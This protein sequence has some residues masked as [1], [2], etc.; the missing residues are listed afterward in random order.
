MQQFDEFFGMKEKSYTENYDN[1][2]QRKAL[3]IEEEEEDDEEN[4]QADDDDEDENKV[5]EDFV[6]PRYL[7]QNPDARSTPSPS[8]PFRMQKV[9]C[10]FKFISR[11]TLLFCFSSPEFKT[12]V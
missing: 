11:K 10:F 6:P 8:L 3:V 1:D 2:I 7:P 5:T 9:F 12:D 4:E